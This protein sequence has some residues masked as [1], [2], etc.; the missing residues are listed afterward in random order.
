VNNSD[1]SLRADKLNEN[2][3]WLGRMMKLMTGES[4]EMRGFYRDEKGVF[5][6]LTSGS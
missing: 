4:P 5:R 2:N 3:S 6:V 1:G